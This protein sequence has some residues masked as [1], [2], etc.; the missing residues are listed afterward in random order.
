MA[1][2]LP[3]DRARET[4]ARAIAAQLDQPL[5]ATLDADAAARFAEAL[6]VQDVRTKG[7]SLANDANATRVDAPFASVDAEAALIVV[8]HA[9]DFGGGW[10][11]ALHAYH[12][13]GAWQTVKPGIEALYAAAPTLPAVWLASRTEAD[14]QT[15]FGIVGDT[16]EALALAP[17]VAQLTAVTN[18]LGTAICDAG[19]STVAE[20]LTSR[21]EASSGPGSTPA[22]AL[23]GDLVSTFPRTF[24]DRYILRDGT[25]ERM[26]VALFKKVSFNRAPCQTPRLLL[27]E[28]ALTICSTKAQ[29]VVGELY[30]RFREEDS[31]FAF[32]DGHRLTAFI[33]N[34][35]VAVLRKVG[36][37]RCCD[38]LTASIEAN[39]L[40]PSGSEAE[41]SLRAAAMAGVEEIAKLRS[42]DGLT[43]VELGNFLW[44][45]LGKT[46]EYRKFARHATRDN[47]F[48]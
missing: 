5:P 6:D 33:D 36:V 32:S 21:M 42:A 41:V 43:P 13:K 12:G 1:E 3:Y 30:H 31:R 47:V 48:Y 16:S 38:A 27:T 37:V 34:V 23:V 11:L 24:D 25:T 18:E 44:G 26:E 40:L 22:A 39:E 15:L 28:A 19:C 4:C 10:R 9:L 20:W 17:F 8:M 7:A 45:Y 46:P 14:I 29:L 2:V 35:I